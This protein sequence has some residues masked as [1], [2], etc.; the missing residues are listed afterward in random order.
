MRNQISEKKSDNPDLKNNSNEEIKSDVSHGHNCGHLHNHNYGD[1]HIHCNCSNES[2]PKDKTARFMIAFI[3]DFFMILKY[4]VIGALCSAFFS[5]YNP[6]DLYSNPQ[7]VNTGS[8]F[9]MMIMAVVLSVC[10]EADAF[11][12]YSFNY[13][14]IASK[15]AFMWLGPIMDIK[16]MILYA[17]IFNK[18]FMFK[19]FSA[20]IIIVILFSFIYSSLII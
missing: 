13:F 7:I 16:L 5:Y 9:I 18:K 11:V 19:I 4:L 12:A 2:N 20:A 3:N 10:S 17:G 6:V 8:I 14:P 1:N 15:M